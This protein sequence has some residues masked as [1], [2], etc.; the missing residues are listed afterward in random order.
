VIDFLL[1]AGFRTRAGPR[2]NADDITH[3]CG[4]FL[5]HRGE[6]YIQYY[7]TK[8]KD[9]IYVWIPLNAKIPYLV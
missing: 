9:N 8:R 6:K 4:L 7:T 3:T 5:T 1:W 2:I